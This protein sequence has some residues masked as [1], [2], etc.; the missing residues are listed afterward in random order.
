VAGDEARFVKVRADKLDHLI[1]LIGELVIAGSG[2]QMVANHEGSPAFLE[3][4]Q[5]VADLVQA[6]RD[7]ALALRMVPVGE[8]FS[9][10][11]RVVRDTSKQLGKE[12]EFVGH[13]RRHRTRQEHGRGDRRPADAPGAQQPGPRHRDCRPSA[14]PPASPPPAGWAERLPRRRQRSSSRSATTAAACA[15]TASWPRPSSAAW[16]PADAAAAATPRSGS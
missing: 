4:T 13:R 7:G 5:R 14:W 16:S 8:T 1:D 10:F 11:Q 15:A 6:T 12:I 3:A 9:R 2:A